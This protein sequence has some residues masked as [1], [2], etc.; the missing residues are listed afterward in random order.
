LYWYK[1]RQVD[2]WNR[3]E[4]PELYLHV[5]DYLIFDKETKK[6]SGKKTAYST[7]DAGLSG[8]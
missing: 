8:G 4:D 5:Y 7:N 3:T 6:Y 1:D 2:K